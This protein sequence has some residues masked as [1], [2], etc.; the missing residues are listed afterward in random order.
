MKFSAIVSLFAVAV[1]AQKS[2]EQIVSEHQERFRLAKR[3]VVPSNDSDETVSAF[4]AS[5]QDRYIILFE[6]G[7]SLQT[8]EEH[9]NQV[10][11]MTSAQGAISN[12]FGSLA[13]IGHKIT[14]GIEGTYAFGTAKEG[15][16]SLYGYYGKFSADTVEKIKNTKGVK[17]VEKDSIE[18]IAAPAVQFDEVPEE[19]TLAKRQSSPTYYLKQNAT[20]GI[21][22]ISQRNNPL[23]T[24]T[25]GFYYFRG[26]TTGAAPLVYVID[27]G[28]RTTHKQFYGRASF[29]AN[30]IDDVDTDENGHGTH[31]AGTIGA[32]DYGVS[33]WTRLI[34]V[35]IFD[36]N[37]NGSLSGFLSGLSWAIDHHLKNP[38]QRAIVNY[39]GSGAVSQARDAAVARAIAA[40]L[41]VVA[42]AGNAAGNA[43]DVGPANN[44]NV[45]GFISVAASDN[46]DAIA[47]FSNFGKCVNVFAPGVDILSLS[48]QSDTGLATMSGTSMATPHV[49]GIMSY[50]LTLNLGMTPAQMA[51]L[52]TENATPIKIKG[53][54]PDTVNLMANNLVFDSNSP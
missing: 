45:T 10:D 44:A 21:S 22:R 53:N 35:K 9:Y 46:E 4:A 51:D 54:H 36:K 27:T 14:Q 33:M 6:Q 29:G 16:Q 1:A 5:V 32:Y 41:P 31:V 39:S 28:I 23:G 30:F 47:G 24:N 48:F 8:R 52:L 50:W 20:W 34:S 12:V 38:S 37:R 42:A 43:C 19:Q 40:G 49:S 17:V 13:D 18:T 11:T 7:A 3:D 26:A 15:S 2:I 25:E